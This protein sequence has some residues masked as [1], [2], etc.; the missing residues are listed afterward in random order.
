[1]LGGDATAVGGFSAR[2]TGVVFPGETIRVRGWRE[3]GRIVASASVAGQDERDGSP[4]LADCVL[5]LA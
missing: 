2:F 5:D 1:M 3:D 4:V